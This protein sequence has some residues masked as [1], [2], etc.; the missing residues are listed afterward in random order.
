MGYLAK[1][2]VIMRTKNRA[3]LLERALNS[4]LD[5]TF[6]DWFLVVVNDGG[7]P[8][9]VDRLVS[10][11][12][13]RFAGRVAVIHNETSHGMEAAS[14]QGIAYG[15]S[16]Y[17]VIH[18]DDDTWAPNFLLMCVNELER[19]G[20]PWPSVQ[21]VISYSLRVLEHIDRGSVSTE[22]IEEFNTWI[23]QGVLSFFR[24]SEQNMFPPI[25]FLYRRAVLD[26]VGRYNEALPVLGDWEFNLRFMSHFDIML[27][28]YALAFYHHRLE[29]TGALGNSV[30]HGLRSHEVYDQ[31]VR[32]EL[33]RQDMRGNATGAATGLG[34]VVNLAQQMSKTQHQVN[35]IREYLIGSTQ[36]ITVAAAGTLSAAGAGKRWLPVW[37]MASFLTF[38]RSADKR[39]LL[40]KF[41]KHWRSENPRR[42]LSVLVRYGYLALGG[43]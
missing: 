34:L 16:E 1:V 32:N 7:N 42:A 39:M 20:T 30:I 6:E 38:A 37:F 28:P 31:F 40:R 35:D 3:L 4:V 22:R 43:K 25:S 24:M 11:Y 5:Q 8:E 12:A 23:P 19:I 41:V 33:L 15:E 26:V 13:D 21:G 9:P 18:D 17:L 2:A 29:A 14:N 10:K 27:V 36:G